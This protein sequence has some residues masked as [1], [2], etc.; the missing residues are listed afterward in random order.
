M[1]EASRAAGVPVLLLGIELPVNYGPQY[2]DGLRAIYADLAARYH[3]GLLPFL[4]D[5]VALK[6]EWMQADGM[7]PN[8]A[9]QA[10]VFANVW[11]ALQP[12]LRPAP[13][14]TR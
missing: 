7:H 9:G 1:I 14:A 4:L 5:G 2:R 13:T 8:A 11:A 12:M 3:T 10:R 6:P